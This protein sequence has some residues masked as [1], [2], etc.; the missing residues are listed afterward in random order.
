MTTPEERQH[1]YRKG[2]YR[3]FRNPRTKQLTALPGDETS[4]AFADAYDPLLRAL[5]GANDPAPAPLPPA[6]RPAAFVPGSIGWFIEQ[7]VAS[8]KYLKL[9]PKTREGYLAVFDVMKEEIG[10]AMLHDVTPQGVDVYSAKIARM[11]SASIADVHTTLLSNLWEFAK[12]FEEFQRG[13]RLCPTIGRTRHYEHDG[14]GH[15]V[16]PEEVIDKFDGWAEPHLRRYRMGLQYT[17]QRGVDVVKM[18]WSDYDGELINVVQ[19]KT[20]ERIWLHCPDVL[21]T[22]LDGMERVNEFIF[23]NMWKRPYASAASLSNCIALHL[24][25]IGHPDFTMHG[26]RKN[27]GME[28]AM[29][30][31]TVS[32]IMAVLGHRSPKMAIFYVQQSDKKRLGRTATIKWNA[33]VDERRTERVAERT[34]QVAER[35]A[36]IKAL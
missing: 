29:A 25:K 10:A 36:N 21:R 34:A 2:K 11:R 7:Y 26:L 27:A 15:L 9:A 23:T 3:Y 20:G 24:E 17:G 1:I 16:W 22:M 33:Y 31:C 30:G 5:E 28:L 4:Q 12:G 32:E 19:Q 35:R 13:D 6:P 14:E 18:K 8:K